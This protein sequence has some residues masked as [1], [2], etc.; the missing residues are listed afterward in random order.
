MW[1]VVTST[2]AALTLVS[3]V[4][5]AQ[6]PCTTD[7]NRVVSEVYRHVLERGTDAGAQTWARRLA[8]GQINV[9]ELM[10]GVA[11]SQEYMQRFG[12][13]EAGERQPFERAVAGLYR[14][15]LGR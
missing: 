14:H 4:A 10:R 6:Q 13:S 1:R 8:N 7:A 5:A 15:V 12:R 9:R 3:S 2:F 11:Q